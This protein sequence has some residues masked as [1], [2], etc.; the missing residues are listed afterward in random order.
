MI[1]SIIGF[2]LAGIGMYIYIR[3]SK[4]VLE[5]SILLVGGAFMAGIGIACMCFL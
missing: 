4:Y 1:L 3:Y 2:I 5:G